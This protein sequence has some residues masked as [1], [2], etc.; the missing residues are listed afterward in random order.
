MP[1]RGTNIPHALEWRSHVLQVLSPHPTARGPRALTGEA[2]SPQSPCRR[3][4]LRPAGKALSCHNA[5]PTR[6]G[7][8][9]AYHSAATVLLAGDSDNHISLNS[10][11]VG[12]ALRVWPDSDNKNE[13][14]STGSTVT[15]QRQHLE[16]HHRF[17]AF[18]RWLSFPREDLSKQTC[19]LSSRTW[20]TG[21]RS[22]S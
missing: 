5:D 11:Q 8:K 14:W 18:G 20:A 6:T 1:G 21:W 12:E 2:C 22:G 15:A 9:P 19:R 17:P 4:S 3:Q 13:L 10:V 7:V 16:F